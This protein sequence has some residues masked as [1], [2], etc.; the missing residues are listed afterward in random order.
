[1]MKQL[2][3]SQLSSV[4]ATAVRRL[5]DGAETLTANSPA[6]PDCQSGWMTQAGSTRHQLG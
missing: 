5:L 4:A 6:Q 2:D 1:M 3:L